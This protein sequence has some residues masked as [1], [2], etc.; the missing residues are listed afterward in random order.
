MSK[1]LENIGI[2]L[3]RKV[4]NKNFKKNFHDF[5]D[6]SWCKHCGKNILE[7]HPEYKEAHKQLY[8]E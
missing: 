3:F 4:A 7:I 2:N 6:G 8:G 5:G 1:K